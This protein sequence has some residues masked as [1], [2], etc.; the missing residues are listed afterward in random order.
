MKEKE[1]TVLSFD[2]KKPQVIWMKLGILPGDSQAL[3]GPCLPVIVLSTF[4]IYWHHRVSMSCR[5]NELKLK[6]IVVTEGKKSLKMLP[7]N[8]NIW[9]LIASHF[10][11]L[12][13]NL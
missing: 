4:T 3:P 1:K 10:K 11:S 12:N 6:F 13:L 7:K 9:N 8:R 2:T 5:W